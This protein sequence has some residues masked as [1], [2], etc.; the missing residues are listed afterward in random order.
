M[1][2]LDEHDSES[3]HEN[4][5][6]LSDNDLKGGDGSN[7]LENLLRAGSGAAAARAGTSL[8]SN[9]WASQSMF[10]NRMVGQ[11]SEGSEQAGLLARQK[12]DTHGLFGNTGNDDVDATDNSSSS[13]NK[14]MFKDDSGVTERVRKKETD[15]KIYHYHEFM[16]KVMHPDHVNIATAIKNFLMSV[17]GPTNDCRHPPPGTKLDYE[18]HGVSRLAARCD[19]FMSA[20]VEHLRVTPGWSGDTDERYISARDCLEKCIM[21]N[22]HKYAFESVMSPADDEE[23]LTRMKLLSFVPASA[24]DI[25]PELVNDL[26]F[27]LARDE[28]SK[29]NAYTLPAD[30][31]ACVTRCAAVIFRSLNLARAKTEE[32]LSDSALGADDFLPMFILVVMRSQ[33]PQLYSNCEY[34]QSFHSPDQMRSKAGYCFVN[35]RYAFCDCWKLYYG[36]YFKLT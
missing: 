23:L 18:F 7:E 3:D 31:I 35:L 2:V 10:H 26:V 16:S 36:N 5:F 4:I 19:D 1:E 17:L 27:A 14:A 15:K 11:D 32:N 25:K 24:L 29:I 12:M 21:G 28:L 34:I 20:I 33:V 6:G 8:D 13:K 22:L 30:K 9:F